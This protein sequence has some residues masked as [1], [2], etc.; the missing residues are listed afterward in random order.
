[1]KVVFLNVR[2]DRKG[3]INK[4]FMGGYG[5]VS[6][7]GNSLPAKLLDV[8][9][10]RGTHLPLMSYGYLA[11]IF[12]SHGHEVEVVT[13]EVPNADLIFIQSSMVEHRA[14]LS[15][16]NRIRQESKAKVGFIGPFSTEMPELFDDQSD[17]IILGEPEA[18]AI[19]IAKGDV[20]KGRVVSARVEDLDDLPFP[21]WD[22]FSYREFSYIPI[23]KEKPFFPVLSSRGCPL[24]C[25]YCPYMSN[26]AWNERSV[27]NV[28]DE[29]G[30]LLEH[31]QARGMLFRDP[32]FSVNKKRARAIGE[33][34]IARNFNHLRWACETKIESLDES[35]LE[36]LYEAGLRVINVAVESQ[37]PAVVKHADRTPISFQ[38]QERILSFCDRLGIRVTVFYVLG[39]PADTRESIEMSVRYAK[40]L[41]SHVA[42][43]FIFTPF[44]GTPYYE[45]VK[46]MI[47]EDD[48]ERFD[49]FTP[50][51][52]HP[53]LGKEELLKL[54]EKA[55]VS[56]YYRPRYAWKFF[57]RVIRDFL[58]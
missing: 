4:D 23:L 54:K 51:I 9:K 11:A 21:R 36:V 13:N 31:Y 6:N 34:M 1:M 29:V 18:A 46:D 26:Y 52:E 33:G 49:C 42:H 25:K 37:D 41:N 22:F 48:W 55:Y 15:W 2:S 44:P 56:Y 39:M 7:V 45:E 50:V 5:W 24:T 38:H 14:E 19:D 20:P 35:L 28:L 58:G 17:F 3:C 40:M 27:E 30:Y 10:K 53:Q 57:T 47:C 43:F 16:A 12:D 8:V 32:F